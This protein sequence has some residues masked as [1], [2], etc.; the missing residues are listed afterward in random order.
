MEWLGGW[1]GPISVELKGIVSRNLK[2]KMYL[3]VGAGGGGGAERGGLF[4]L[5]FTVVELKRHTRWIKD[6]KCRSPI[7]LGAF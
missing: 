1:T 6:T 7:I 3:G 5:S 4:I 2:Y